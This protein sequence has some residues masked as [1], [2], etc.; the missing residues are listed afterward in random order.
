[1]GLNL[2]RQCLEKKENL[3]IAHT[4]RMPHEE[5]ARDQGDAPII[6]SARACSVAHLCPTLCD[7]MDSGPPGSSVHKISQARILEQVAITSSRGSSRLR[8]LT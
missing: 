4:W 3:D 8:D 6:Q 7:L 1:M 2:I 5:E